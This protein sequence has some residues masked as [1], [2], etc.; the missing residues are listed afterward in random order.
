MVTIIANKMHGHELGTYT[1]A[2]RTFIKGI[3]ENNYLVEPN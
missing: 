1:W 2:D 3:F